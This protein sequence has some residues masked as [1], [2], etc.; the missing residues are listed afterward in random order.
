MSFKER[1]MEK[2]IIPDKENKMTTLFI[3]GI[4]LTR[5]KKFRDSE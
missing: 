1:V 5:L 4:K 3:N 2:L